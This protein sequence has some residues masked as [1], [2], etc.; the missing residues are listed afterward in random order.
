VTT[1]LTAPAPS[2]PLALA[3][4]E[5]EQR[6]ATWAAASAAPAPRV[7][8][9]G[10][11]DAL[12]PEPAAAV[13]RRALATVHLTAESVLI[14]PWGGVS[15]ACGNCLAMRWQ[16]LRCSAERDALETGT[17][18]AATTAGCWP[19]ITDFTAAAVWAV[20]SRI[21]DAADADL[22]QVTA[23]DLATLRTTTVPLLADPLCP[24]CAATGPGRRA[25]EPELP[26]I[27]RPHTSDRSHR[28][29]SPGSYALP[30]SAL[31]NPVCGVLGSGIWTDLSS[32]TMAP[33]AGNILMRT[34]LGLG[35]MNWSGK[36]TSYRASRDL[37]LLEGLERYAGTHRRYDSPP[38]V[39][40]YETLRDRGV[41]ALDPRDCGEYPRGTHAADAGPGPFDPF[42]PISWV[43]GYSLR[44]ELPILVPLRLAYYCEGTAADGLVDECSNGCAIGSCLEE[45][46]LSGLLELIERDAFLL[47]W[48][49]GTPL[50]E[51][52]LPSCDSAA[53]RAMVDRARLSGYRIHA[54]DTR[55]DLPVPVVTSL[56]V[57]EDGGLGTLSFA[58]A[59]GFEPSAA[60]EAAIAETL[61]YI[62]QLPERIEQRLP[63]I[64]AM[65]QDFDL[66]GGLPDHSALF[67][68]PEMAQ[69]AATYLAPS[70]VRPAE[71]VYADW[72][73][74]RPRTRN[75]LEDV[76]FCRDALVRA[77]H[78]VIVVDQTSPE[79]EQL[80]LRTVRMIVP[81]LLPIDFGWTRQRALG[82]PRLHD[83]VERRGGALRRI[84]HPFS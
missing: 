41:A 16:R 21:A 61:T 1:L 38:L 42:R 71:S 26:L 6:L 69:H 53:I 34:R 8:T 56:A 28:L 29:R 39:E 65:V 23:I 82:M 84:P 49:A 59:A 48:Y 37:A 2:R 62:P 31:A 51:I 3:Q 13:A 79:Q 68:L 50:T 4:R 43:Q 9:L 20:H 17:G 67:G 80:G 64:T 72:Q 75:L 18:T 40:S 57:R 32:P 73:R 15:D 63:E 74:Q 19:L 14:G 44:S 22:P 25:E 35:D 81:G 60:I 83:V 78:D 7:S 76:R 70:S 52:D 12:R 11:T 30:A 54:F 58:A 27:S 47:A 55:S 45:A 77:G 36:S 66:V 46:V 33:V 5:L 10:D 24:H